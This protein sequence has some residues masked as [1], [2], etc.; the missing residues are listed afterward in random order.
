MKCPQCSTE[1]SDDSSFCSKCGMPIHPSEG[2]QIS[3]TRTI[4]RRQDELTPGTVLAEKYRIA[5]V[6]GRGG[7]DVV[8]KAED[9]QLKRNVALKF[10]PSELVS[11]KV[12]YLWHLPLDKMRLK[13]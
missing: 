6:V 9:T 5:E 2:I 13:Y 11:E 10:L 4:L 12:H 7:M 8:Y 1:I 3:Q